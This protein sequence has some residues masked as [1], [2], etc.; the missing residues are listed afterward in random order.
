M[1]LIV[2]SLWAAPV[3]ASPNNFEVQRHAALDQA[4]RVAKRYTR[5][6]RSR[7]AEWLERSTA[8]FPTQVAPD[9][10]RA[11]PAGGPITSPERAIALALGAS[12]SDQWTVDVGEAG[13]RLDKF[14]ASPVDLPRA[15]VP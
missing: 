11:A 6:L 7:A 2:D 10:F 1:I 5:R 13:V 4:A 3:A 12:L 9:A 15:V 14:L 8:W